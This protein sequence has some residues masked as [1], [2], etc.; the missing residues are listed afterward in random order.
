MLVR[1]PD[2][3]TDSFVYECKTTKQVLQY[4][5][6]PVALAQANLYGAFSK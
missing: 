3:I 6:K 1:V 5:I 2:G 4:Y